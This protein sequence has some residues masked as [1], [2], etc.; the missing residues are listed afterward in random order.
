MCLFYSQLEQLFVARILHRIDTRTLNTATRRNKVPLIS[1]PEAIYFRRGALQG[2]Q[3]ARRVLLVHGC[4][5]PDAAL[6]RDVARQQLGLCCLALPWRHIVVIVVLLHF[7]FCLT[8]R[9]KN[10]I[11]S[12]TSGQ[13]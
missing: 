13:L 12:L 10:L 4:P 11:I 6:G 8:V 5:V 9:V 2:P 7:S 1:A 3:T